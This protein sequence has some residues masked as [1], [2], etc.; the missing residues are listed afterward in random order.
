MNQYSQL[1]RVSFS[2]PPNT[3]R[4]RLIRQLPG[5]MPG[6]YLIYIYIYCIAVWVCFCWFICSRVQFYPLEN[7]F[8]LPSYTQTLCLIEINQVFQSSS[9]SPYIHI[10]IDLGHMYK[11]KVKKEIKAVE[12]YYKSRKQHRIQ[13]IIFEYIYYIL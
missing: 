5:P 10:Y 4:V 3:T 8:L 1:K 2:P 13:S 9:G 12:S 11:D 7:S 6:R